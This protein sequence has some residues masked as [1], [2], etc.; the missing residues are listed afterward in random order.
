MARVG[1]APLQVTF[2]SDHRK[3]YTQHTQ[4]STPDALHFDTGQDQF[5]DSI[6]N[7]PCS[8]YHVETDAPQIS[9]YNP[10]GTKRSIDPFPQQ[11]VARWARPRSDLSTVMRKNSLSH[12]L[13]A[14]WAQVWWPQPRGR[15]WITMAILCLR[16]RARLRLVRQRCLILFREMGRGMERMGHGGGESAAVH[17]W[18][19]RE[20]MSALSLRGGKGLITLHRH[21]RPHRHQPMLLRSQSACASLLHLGYPSLGGGSWSTSRQWGGMHLRGSIQQTTG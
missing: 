11:V 8:Q 15:V 7:R 1:V 14:A 13:L 12:H 17:L 18:R 4:L 9:H 16:P 21:R 20:V 2:D 6:A 10:P 19:E 3:I 5:Q